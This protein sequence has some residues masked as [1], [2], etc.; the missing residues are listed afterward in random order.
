VDREPV[1]MVG[2]GMVVQIFVDKLQKTNVSN[3]LFFM[4]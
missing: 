4:I 3:E 1:I 2:R